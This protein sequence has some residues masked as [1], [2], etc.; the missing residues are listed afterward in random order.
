MRR[1]SREPASPNG[2]DAVTKTFQPFLRGSAALALA[3]APLATT[4]PAWAKKEPIFADS[5]GPPP[6]WK[7]YKALAEEAVRARLI[8]PSS[9]QFKWPYGYKQRGYTPFMHKRVYGYSTCG[10]VNSRNSYG[11]YVGDT[12]FAIVIDYDQVLYVDLGKPN[13]FDMVSQACS[14][15]MLPAAPSD[16][17]PASAPLG[18]SLT[19]TPD[20][21]YVSNVAE[22]SS[23]AAAGI[24]SGMVIARI[25]GIS[26]KGM[27][28]SAIDQMLAGAGGPINL[29][30]IGGK[31]ITVHAK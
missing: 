12:F 10:F 13:G 3:V 4:P 26:I 9:A 16:N 11:G 31:T 15:A 29:D 14:K 1:V 5:Y 18:L 8:D 23:G 27:P 24:Q 28:A 19:I 25:N 21:A 6:E 7:R 30:M 2:G 22:G 17:A 20:G